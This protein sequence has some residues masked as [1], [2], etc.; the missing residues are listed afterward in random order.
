MGLT[1]QS[2]TAASLYN[3][4]ESKSL[5]R[6]LGIINNPDDAILLT[7]LLLDSSS[8]VQPMEAYRFLRSIKKTDRI[9]VD[10]LVHYRDDT[11]MFQDQDT[12][13]QLGKDL[14][15]WIN[16]L[17]HETVPV[18]I[19][20]LGNELLIDRAKKHSDLLCTIE[21]V[22]SF[23]L[24]AEAW[25]A[26]HTTGNLKDFLDYVGRLEG[27][28][29]QID[30][31]AF[32]PEKGIQIMTLHKSK[33]LEYEYV[34]IAHMNEEIVMSEKRNAFTLPEKIQERIHER[35]I[36]SAKRELYVALTRA[37]R[38]A[39][40]SYAQNSDAGS[41]L[42]LVR[43]ID[44]LSRNQLVEISA[45]ENEKKIM[46][47]NPRLYAAKPIKTEEGDIKESVKDFVKDS[48]TETRVSV[49]LLNNFFE[50]PWKWYF[51][52]FL[53]LPDVKG[54]SLALG[55]AVHA[56]IELLLKSSSLPKKVEIKSIIDQALR[57]EGVLDERDI[58]RLGKDALAA[59]TTWI[60]GYYDH[61]ASDRKSERSISYRDPQFSNL[62]MFGKI[63]LT[64]RFPDGTMTVTDFKT[65]S[66]KTSGMIE[67]IDDE[68]RMSDYLRQLAMYSYLIAGTESG[69]R[70]DQS[71]LLF[72][73]AAENDK[74]ALYS[75]A[76]T[77]HE[78]ELLTKDIADYQSLLET[79][80]WMSR[81]CHVKTYGTG[82]SECEF[83][84]R[85]AVIL[86]K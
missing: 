28:G 52:N 11:G 82:S 54:V 1:V 86:G 84:K 80:E 72:L 9:T 22:R 77:D 41:D 14:M 85:A 73:E 8:N 34:W 24:T 18:I 47:H 15:R 53:R 78:L 74:N 76:I 59:V 37:K 2:G 23:I 49:T 33:G 83:C 67:K 17:T 79:G 57:H 7:E 3:L 50:C 45:E 46:E 66:S 69:K 75:K 10:D 44:E 39:V 19:G 81:P 70:V 4:N 65:G 13:V 36:M 6:A 62:T 21:V 64:E 43:I 30:L 35:D 38:F 5:L 20:V 68:G 51:R 55:S 58:A 56:T 25:Q 42:E 31:A 60:D 12:I 71:R 16:D 26:K 61:L 63:D 32:A 40:F 29:S 27:Y 48:F